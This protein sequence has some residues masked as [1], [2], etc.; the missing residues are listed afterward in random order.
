M[1]ETPIKSSEADD[2]VKLET[3]MYSGSWLYNS[4]D[5]GE[6]NYIDPGANDYI[7]GC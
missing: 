3:S 4:L 5:M 1:D 2:S 6:R 7:E